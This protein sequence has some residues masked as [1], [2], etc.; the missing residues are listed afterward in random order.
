[1]SFVLVCLKAIDDALH[2]RRV[3]VED[4]CF[5]HNEFSGNAGKS[6]P[7]KERFRGFNHFVRFETELLLERFFRR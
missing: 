2:Q 7:A 1:M 6:L 4:R 5:K 3:Q